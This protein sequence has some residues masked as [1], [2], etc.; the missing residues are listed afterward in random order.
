VISSQYTYN[1]LQGFQLNVSNVD[2]REYKCTTDSSFTSDVDVVNVVVSEGLLNPTPHPKETNLKIVLGPGLSATC[3][4]IRPLQGSNSKL[5]LTNVYAE[6]PL[7]AKI[8]ADCV[9]KVC[10]GSV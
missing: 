10:T 9:L 5:E 4:G 1:P 2:A 7:D 8:L 6:N 3:H